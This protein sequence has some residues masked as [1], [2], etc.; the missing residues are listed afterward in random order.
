MLARPTEWVPKSSVEQ[1]TNTLSLEASIFA[2]PIDLVETSPWEEC[3]PPTSVENNLSLSE[4]QFQPIVRSVSQR[5]PLS[6]STT[7]YDQPRKLTAGNLTAKKSAAVPPL[8]VRLFICERCYR[9]ACH[10]ENFF[11]DFKPLNRC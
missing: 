7:V 2:C 8:T 6:C 1:T 3:G 11:W 9:T 4:K 5:L 10:R